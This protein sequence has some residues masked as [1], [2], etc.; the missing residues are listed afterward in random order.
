MTCP[1]HHFIVDTPNGPTSKGKCKRCH[2]TRVF[3]NTMHE[4]RLIGVPKT[5]AAKAAIR[6]SH[7]AAR[8]ARAEKDANA[9]HAAGAYL[10]T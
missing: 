8:D 9:E 7:Q 3:A 10:E 4:S 2:T 6:A 5:D 1:P